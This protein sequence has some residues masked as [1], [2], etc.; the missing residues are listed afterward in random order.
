MHEYLFYYY[1]VIT[2]K[3]EILVCQVCVCVHAAYL[4]KKIV[5]LFISS[6]MT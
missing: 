3:R 4:Y 2:V 5:Y 1:K 6:S